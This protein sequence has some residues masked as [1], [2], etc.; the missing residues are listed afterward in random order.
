MHTAGR[1]P[2]SATEKV[3]AAAAAVATAGSAPRGRAGTLTLSGDTRVTRTLS[4]A[5]APEMAGM[6]ES[7]ADHQP[8]QTFNEEANQDALTASK[9][10]LSRYLSKPVV[11]LFQSQLGPIISLLVDSFCSGLE[12]RLKG[13]TD[14]C[15][16]NKYLLLTVSVNAG[17]GDA[18]KLQSAISSLSMRQIDVANKQFKEWGETYV[19]QEAADIFASYQKDA[20]FLLAKVHPPVCRLSYK[21]LFLMFNLCLCSFPPR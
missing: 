3:A 1:A 12:P 13:I 4:A 2:Q 20:G 8:L 16:A 21:L 11:G 17:G 19:G 6:R 7:V 9:A 10:S 15:A 14:W 18:E 5:V